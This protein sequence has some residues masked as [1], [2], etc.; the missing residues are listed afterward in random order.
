MRTIHLRIV[1]AALALTAAAW[2]ASTAAAGSKNDKPG[3]DAAH[4]YVSVGD[5][6]AAGTQPGK[7]FSNEGYADQLYAS[8]AQQD[9]KLQLVKLGCPGETTQ[10]MITGIQSPCPHQYGS[11]IGDVVVCLQQH[12]KSVRYITI[13]IGANDVL[14]CAS[15][16]TRSPLAMSSTAPRAMVRV[17]S[18]RI[19]TIS[20]ATTGGSSPGATGDD[21]PARTS[22]WE[23][24]SSMVSLRR[25]P[26]FVR[27]FRMGTNAV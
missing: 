19:S 18:E 9:P 5:S 21:V 23:R 14:P 7:P 11:Q 8:L 16:A 13:D 20:R 3:N 27:R 15:T 6:V 24:A 10:S 25:L 12:S 4:Y 2:A 22:A 26:S 1:V 17:P